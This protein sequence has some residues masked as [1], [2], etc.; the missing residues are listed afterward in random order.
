MIPNTIWKYSVT[1]MISLYLKIF[2]ITLIE[3]RSVAY[4]K[5]ACAYCNLFLMYDLYMSGHIHYLKHST[6]LHLVSVLLNLL[7]ILFVG[8]EILSLVPERFR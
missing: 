1:K 2:P 8:K 3:C 7:G 5:K 6:K 4:L